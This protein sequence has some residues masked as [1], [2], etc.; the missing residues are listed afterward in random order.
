MNNLDIIKKS[1]RK[2]LTLSVCVLALSSCQLDYENK[3][4]INPDNVWQN[5]TM[6]QAYLTDIYSDMVPG[7]SS[8]SDTDTD[9]TTDSNDSMSEWLRGINISASSCGG[10]FNYTIIDKINY[11]LEQLETVPESVM[12]LK[13]KDAVVAQAK[14]WRAYRYWSY[15]K[16]LG[17]VPL[18]LKS[19]DVNDLPSLKVKRSS[20]SDCMAQIVKD[21]D[22]AIQGLPDRWS[23]VDYG[24][25][26]KCAAMAFKGR[27]QMWYASKLFNRSND[28]GRWEMAYKTNKEALEQA[29]KSGYKLMDKFSDIWLTKGK[30][31]TEA[32]I[33]RNY[34]HPD[35]YYDMNQYLP[36]EITHGWACR[37][38][39]QTPQ[40]LAF[41]LKDGSSMAIYENEE[42]KSQKLDVNRL[43]T[44]AAY[45]A[46][47]LGKLVNGMDPRF[48][49]SYS[50]PGGEFPSLEIPAGQYLWT[51]YVKTEAFYR[52]MSNL[53]LKPNAGTT[54]YGS[55]FPLKAITPGLN[56]ADSYKGENNAIALRL[57]EVYLNLAECAAEA[58]HIGEA[59]GY[60]ATLRRR[61][62]IDK[63][64]GIIG[65]GLDVYN[66]IEGV[67]RLLYNERAAELSQE[68]MRYGDL[69]RWMNFDNINA[70]KHYN[71]LYVVFNGDLEEAG[72]FDWTRTLK[73][74]DTQKFFHIDFVPNVKQV[75]VSTFNIST[76]HWFG[77]IGDKTM[78][79]N[80][81]NDMSQQNNEWGGSFDPLK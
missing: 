45:N 13:D 69:R 73:D 55:F 52:A 21:L 39:P 48:Y 9:L 8:T 19:Q 35:S 64:V 40:L 6:I 51:A 17:G 50:I 70:Q 59:L 23:G 2:F 47:I 62:G 74:A 68:N 14:F 57:G 25:I 63:G 7:W 32:L 42:Y 28:K 67:R 80:F 78:G 77:A 54:H 75:E 65:Y 81:D 38:V 27:V 33:Y 30:S 79:A 44:D 31:N 26:D 66:T 43:S 1:G 71:N 41:P 61:A 15:V 3:S 34:K 58:G 4:A 11:L 36:E 20:T 10:D 5:E 72:K 56:D 16:D 76:K 22:D 24:R 12:A 46:E 37:Q 29:E 18:I 53:Q 49:D 60:V